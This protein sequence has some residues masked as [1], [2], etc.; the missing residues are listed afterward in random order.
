M[1][2][3]CETVAERVALEQ[4]LGDLAEHAATC[5]RCRQLAALPTELAAT[6]RDSDPGLGFSARITAGAQ[7][8][9]VARRRQRIAASAA[10]MVAAAAAATFLILRQPPS[11]AV[12]I[13]SSRSQPA[14]APTMPPANDP[15]RDH[16]HDPV[17]PEVR[18]LVHFAHVE[19]SGQ[20]SA[21]WSDVEKP[22]AP[23]RALLKGVEP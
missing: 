2:S 12:A 4:P 10:G 19:R 13:E 18:T 11:D 3:P 20:A 8:R 5:A 23:Y 15:W 16:S 1:M 14:I 22:L 7:Q 6:H 17:D 21:R 9:L